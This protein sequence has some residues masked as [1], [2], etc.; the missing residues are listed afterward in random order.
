MILEGLELNPEDQTDF[1][2]CFDERAAI[3]EYE[4]GLPRQEAEAQARVIC[5]TE[6]R[7]KKGLKV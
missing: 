5:L 6:Y 3:L 7:N 4:G 2:E 1:N